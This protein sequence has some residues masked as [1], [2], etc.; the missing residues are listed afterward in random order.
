M[1]YL[2][3][4]RECFWD[5]TLIDEG[6]TTAPF[7][8][9]EP[10]RQE[11]VILHDE[12]WEGDGCD[13]YNFFYDDGIYRMYYLAWNTQKP[14]VRAAYAESK[15]G[16]HWVKPK[17]G[18]CEFNGSKENNI[19]LDSTMNPNIDNFMVFRD[20]NPNCR[21]GEKYKAV[22]RYPGEDGK[23]ELW[24]MFSE[25]ALHFT[26][27]NLITK[28]GWFDSLNVIFWDELTGKYRGYIRDFHEKDNFGARGDL[29]YSVRDIR[30]IESD[31]FI[32]W[33]DPVL[34]DFGDAP[35]VPLYT[36]N[37]MPYPRAPQIY[38]GTPSRYIE[39]KAWNGSFDELCGAEK[40]KKRMQDSLR[41]GLTITDCVFMCSHDG[42]TF[43]RHDD[44]FMR[45][46][47]EN[48]RN[49][50]YGDCYPTRGILET[51]SAIQGADPELSIFVHD[52]HW[53]GLSTELYRYTLRCDGFVS[54]HAGGSKEEVVVTKPFCYE[55][56]DMYVNF[57]TSARGYMYFAL[58]AADGRRIESCETFGN[59]ID[60]RV[61][62][63]EGA[64]AEFAGLKVTLEV[65]MLD[66]DLY[67][68]QFR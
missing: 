40:R 45:P 68:M 38:I 36:N 2:K 27:G 17:L 19:I 37:V 62:F 54:L 43:T 18:I 25:D 30:Y 10:V 65:R 5:N 51:P 1:K 31:D 28:K 11:M 33:S 49:W 3:N 46:L 60:R 13:Y 15:D 34:L 35:D 64:V 52:N 4:N 63:P 56:G 26:K 21:P 8:V 16:L 42:V 12:P 29:A 57:A 58:V 39:R 22:V 48:G 24:A 55:G 67:S 9:H 53:V 14:E 41:Y 23:N 6:K 20:D 50:V 32:H 59:S 61:V 66:A 44:A 47:P 7:R